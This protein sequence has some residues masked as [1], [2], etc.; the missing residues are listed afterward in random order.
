VS[1]HTPIQWC[2]STV[3]PTSGCDGCELHNRNAPEK[4]TCY[5]RQ[6]HETRFRFNP[7]FALTG[8]YAPSFDEVRIIPGRVAEAATWGDLRGKLRKDGTK[9]WLDLMPRVIFVGDL[10]DILS[11]EVSDDFIEREIFE[12]MHSAKGRRHVWIV[13]TKRPSRLADLSIARG[14]LPPNCLAMTSVTDQATANA[15]VPQL[16]RVKCEMRGI[17]AEPLHGPVSFSSLEMSPSNGETAGE[18]NRCP[19]GP[20][21]DWIIC[22]GESGEKAKPC[23]VEWLWSIVMECGQAEVP[24][25]VKQLGARPVA[26]NVNIWDFPYAVPD[27]WGSFAGGGSY[28]LRDS[29][30]GDPD[31]WPDELRKRQVPDFASLV[32]ARQMVFNGPAQERRTEENKNGN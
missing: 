20:R 32:D 13:L 29:H 17:S 22:G 12:P 2:D 21:L 24:C 4:S 3:N 1:A 8:N 10:S 30:G 31:E 5:A 28:K 27:A 19:V 14:G 23:P 11:A 9:P 15:R 7:A 18:A 26:E 6:I 16:L 25:F